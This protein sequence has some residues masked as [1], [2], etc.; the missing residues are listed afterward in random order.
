MKDL[1][2]AARERGMTVYERLYEP[3]G[4]EAKQHIKKYDK[5]LELDHEGKKR[6]TPCL[7]HPEYQGWLTG[8]VRDLFS[9]YL[10]DGIQFGA[11]R[12][13]PMGEMLYWNS[14][15]GCFCPYCRQE[16]KDKNIDPDRLRAGFYELYQFLQA[17][18][19]AK[20]PPAGGAWHRYLRVLMQYPELLQW[21]WQWHRAQNEL[22]QMVYNAIK[23]IDPKAQVGR[24]VA[25]I[26]TAM[27]MY[28]RAGAPFEEMAGNN[29]FIKII[30]YHEITG[31]RLHS[32]HLQSLGDSIY[33]GIPH[34]LI[35]VQPDGS[36]QIIPAFW[37]GETTWTFRYSAT[38]EGVYSFTTRCSDAGNA[39]LHGKQGT[40]EVTPCTGDNLLYRHGTLTI[41]EDGT[42]FEH[43]D[44]T[45]FFWLA[46]SWWFGM[47]D[48]L[49]WPGEFQ[50]LARD[51]KQKGFTVIQ[52]ALGFPC[53]IKPMDE[54]GRNA[55][56]IPG[57]T[58]AVYFYDKPGEGR[59]QMGGF[60]PGEIY[61][62]TYYDPRTGDAYDQGTFVLE[63][64]EKYS[65]PAAPIRQDW[66]LIIDQK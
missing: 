59:Y 55:A 27:D 12:S 63:E 30:T 65:V 32:W 51:R 23:E 62:A 1:L 42:H 64:G 34:D 19:T 44:G 25:C 54:R 5:V 66:V 28:Y 11:E 22:H 9:T 8:T 45:P 39:G 47:S 41:S 60:I 3:H 53:D 35:V 46:D 56:G 29:D 21:E 61:L 7:R 38:L 14:K 57:R 18:R 31:P 24:H 20:E 2:P 6:A 36:K 15:P 52:F 33:K 49:R 43:L 37:S 13:G 26:E 50:L 4:E 10:F 16:M 40:I 58:I 48:R 17:L